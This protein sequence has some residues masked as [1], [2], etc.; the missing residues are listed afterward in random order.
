[1]GNVLSSILKDGHLFGYEK[2][3]DGVLRVIELSVT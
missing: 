2:A 3:D 1:M